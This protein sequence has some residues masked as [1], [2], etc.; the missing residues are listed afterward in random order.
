[1][2]LIFMEGFDHYGSS[3]GFL[4]KWSS[5][6]MSID[7]GWKRSGSQSMRAGIGSPTMVTRQFSPTGGFVCGMAYYTNVYGHNGNL[8]EVWEGGVLHMAWGF[9]PTMLPVVKRGTTV[10]A[11]G[12][13]PLTTATWHYIEFKGVID[14]TLGSY[15]LKIDGVVVLSASNID[16]RNA[17]TTGQWT[18]LVF[19]CSSQDQ[20]ID[21]L[22]LLDMSGPAPYNDFLGAIRIEPLYP[23]TD[24]VSIGSNQGLTPSTGTDH[25][26]LVDETTPNTTDYNAS[27]V[28]GAKDTYQLTNP[29]ALYAGVGILGIH[30]LAYAWKLDVG[31]G[32]INVVVR[33]NGVDYDSPVIKQV[34]FARYSYHPWALNPNTG[35]AWTE[36]D[37]AALQ[38]GMK[39]AV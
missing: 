20:W 29:P 15:E 34:T 21:D 7:T 27:A 2:A 17:G 9:A 33:T 28:I 31:P 12:T 23:V 26:A 1:M 37:I 24:A 18:A 8:L 36:A 3:Q 16:T 32:K 10:L 30:A 5:C 22:Y 4:A 11:T 39:V 25:G 6:N 14:D 38:A 19:R 13:T 35:V